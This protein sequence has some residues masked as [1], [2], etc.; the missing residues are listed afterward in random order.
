MLD[1][2]SKRIRRA[3]RVR[4]KI[5]E[6]GVPRLSVHRTPR[7]VYAQIIVS[8]VKGDKVL[9]SASTCDKEVKSAGGVASNVK[10]AGVVGNT[11]AKRALAAGVKQVAFDRS[12]YMYHGCIK[13]LAEAAREGGLQF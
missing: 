9:A 3:K 8:D 11:I 5:K 10:S 1:K 12:G 2:K 6:L 13:A 7:H 4:C